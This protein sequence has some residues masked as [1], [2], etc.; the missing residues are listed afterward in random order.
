[1]LPGRI[2]ELARVAV[3]RRHVPRGRG[4]SGDAR[5]H[6]LRAPALRPLPRRSLLILYVL[7]DGED[8]ALG[9]HEPRDRLDHGRRALHGRLRE[10]ARRTSP[11]D[12]PG[13]IRAPAA[14]DG[15]AGARPCCAA[16]AGR[17]ARSCSSAWAGSCSC[18]PSTSRCARSTSTRRCRPPR[19][20]LLLMNVATIFPLW[21][22]NIGLLQAAVALPLVQYGVA[23]AT[24]FAFGL[25]LQA[26]EMSVGVGVGLIFLA[27]EGLSFATLR[28]CPR[29]A[30]ARRRRKRERVLPRGAVRALACP[31][32][33]KGVLTA[34]RG[35]GGAGGGAARRAA[36]T[37]SSC[38]SR[39]GARERPRCSGS[40][41]AA[42]GATRTSTTRSARRA[43]R[44][45]CC[46]RTGRRS[47][48]R[49]RRC[50]ST[51]LGSTPLAASSRGFG[52]LVQAALDDGGPSARARPR[53]D[54]D[55]GRR[56][57]A[58]R[59]SR[60]RCRC[61]RCAAC[62][63]TATLLD[64]P[65]AVRP[66]EGRRSGRS[67]GARAA[68]RGARRA[69]VYQTQARAPAR[70]AGS[71]PR[72][73]RSAP[74][75]FPA[76]PRARRGRLRR[77]WLRPRRHRRG[78]RRRDD[79]AREGAGRGRCRRGGRRPL[80]RLR[81]ASSKPSSQA[82]RPS[83]SPATRPGPGRPRRAGRRLSV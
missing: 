75:S 44:A 48:S 16:A 23:Y 43:G 13:A 40:P 9:G 76:R 36:P 35:G 61:R 68:A 55:D 45:G 74:T 4:S 60:A 80:R 39:T 69:C 78:S 63:V 24:G 66:A 30:R 73:R 33:L 64:A 5:R 51:R 56:R 47:S 81:R 62:D 49:Q 37:R 27:R 7:A 25:V 54:G 26:I 83:R 59:G 19:L 42:S 65:T 77:R 10:R 22:G 20:V 31:A 17:W 29:R 46:C 38:R 6:G 82:P 53:R 67:R 8:P 50:R 58:A 52:E 57:R 71:A 72:S 79:R 3:L 41:A 1:M 11:L 12:R 2:G 32:S 21:P 15:A 28:E 34:R 70:P 14:R 18:S